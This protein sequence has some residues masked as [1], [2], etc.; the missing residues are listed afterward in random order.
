MNKYLKIIKIVLLSI[1]SIMLICILSL[2]IYSQNYYH[3]DS[4]VT[5]L[6]ENDENIEIIDN[7]TIIKSDNISDKAIIFYPGGKVE[8][9]AY[10]PMLKEISNQGITVVLVKMPLNLAIL[11]INAA[12]RVYELLPEVKEWYLVGH[13]LGGAMSSIYAEKHQDILDG[14]VVLGAY[15]VG[16][17]PTSDALTIYGTFNDNLEEFFDYTENVVV[18]DGGNHAQFGN[19]GKQKGDPDATISAEEQQKQTIKAILDFIG[20]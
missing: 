14:L 7:Y 1:L 9:S 11:N 16:E 5:F 17:Y 19:Y 10:Y 4:D 18:I 15:V 20:N 6:F 2:Y 3:T 12:N 13:S 8:H